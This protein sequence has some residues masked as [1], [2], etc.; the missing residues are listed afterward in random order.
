[1]KTLKLNLVLAMIT[2]TVSGLVT[3]VKKCEYLRERLYLTF[4]NAIKCNELVLALYQQDHPALPR[5]H[6][7]AYLASVIIDD[8]QY[9]IMGSYEQWKAFYSKKWEYLE[10]NCPS[11]IGAN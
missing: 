8:V 11:V 3:A 1:M 10:N 6:K 2:F 5:N 7:S 4:D 9:V